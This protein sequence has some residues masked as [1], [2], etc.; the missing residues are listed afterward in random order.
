MGKSHKIKFIGL[1]VHKNSITI[2]IADGDRA[3]EVRLYGSIKNTVEALDKV[4]RKLLSVGSE[5]QFV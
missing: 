5:L 4:T 3:G 1:D 2:A